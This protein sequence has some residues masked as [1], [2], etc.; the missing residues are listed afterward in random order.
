MWSFSW[1]RSRIVS[2]GT[3]L[4][5]H[6]IPSQSYQHFEA[7]NEMLPGATRRC[8]LEC[9]CVVQVV[10]LD[11]CMSHTMLK[12]EEEWMESGWIYILLEAVADLWA[13][14][15]P[16]D[17]ELLSLML[18]YVL[19]VSPSLSPAQQRCPVSRPLAQ[20]WLVIISLWPLL[21]VFRLLHPF[22]RACFSFSA[23][24]WK[25]VRVHSS[26]HASWLYRKW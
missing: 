12:N 4:K 25:D 13:S 15:A 9:F 11:A 19:S 23:C 10:F 26:E 2:I 20:C 3:V 18:L 5:G 21:P 8:Y 16:P 7:V 1:T 17:N 14:V 6:N 24:F 22:T